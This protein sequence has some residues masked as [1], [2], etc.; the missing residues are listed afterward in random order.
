MPFV[1]NAG[2]VDCSALNIGDYF[3]LGGDTLLVVDRAMLDSLILLHDDLSK[4]C[5]SN[6]TDMKDALARSTLV[7]YRYCL[8]GRE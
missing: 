2:C 4:V 8:L 5:V 7:Q 6:I 3:E 1:N